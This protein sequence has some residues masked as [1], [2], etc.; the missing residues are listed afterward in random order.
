MVQPRTFP[1]P[2]VH[3]THLAVKI[4][5]TS[6]QDKKVVRNS[7]RY[8]LYIYN[9]NYYYYCKLP[10]LFTLLISHASLFVNI[11]ISKRNMVF[12]LTT[13]EAKSFPLHSTTVI[14]GTNISK[15]PSDPW[16]P[17]FNLQM[18]RQ[19]IPPVDVSPARI[20]GPRPSLSSAAAA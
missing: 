16:R 5:E 20:C 18:F 15:T 17:F 3:Q 9:Y 2:G 1:S 13:L 19:S 11:C 6:R 7:S 12:L 4:T 10:V 14:I 8:V